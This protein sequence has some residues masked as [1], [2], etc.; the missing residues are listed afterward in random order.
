MGTA[1][2]GKV[3]ISTAL[4]NSE[5]EKST[6]SMVAT[7]AAQYRKAGMSQSDA[8]KKAWSEVEHTSKKGSEKVNRHIHSMGKATQKVTGVFGGLAAVLTKLGGV[9]GTAFAVHKAIE[10]GTESVKAA[11][12]MS[13]ALTGLQSVVEGQGRSFKQA[14]NFIKEYTADGL[15]PATNAINAYKNLSLRGYD[16]SQIRQVIVALKDSSA[17]GR[18]ASLSMGQAVESAS[19]GL[20]NENSILVDNAGV[21]KNVAKMWD[22]YARSIGTTA[23]NLTQQQK[24]Q[25]EVNGILEESKYQAGDAAKVAGTFSGQLMQLSFNFN[26]LKVAVGNA[27]IP[28]AQRILPVINAM[29]AGLTRLANAVA[30]VM[31]AIFGKAQVVQN[32]QAL[33]SSNGQIASSAGVGAAAEKDLAQNTKKAGKAAKGALAAFDELNVLQQN[34]T[35]SA[36]GNGASGG[37]GAAPGALAPAEMEVEDTLSPRLQAIVDKIH[38]LMEPLK[39]INFQPLIDA[40]ERLKEAAAPLTQ[41]LFA[42]LEWAYYHIF[43]PL[44]AWTAEDFLPVFLDVLA[45]ACRVLTAALGALAPLGEWLWN[46]FLAPIAEWTGGVIVT[47][48]NLLADAL[49]RISDWISEH[50]GIVQGMTII[51]AAFMAAWGGTEL[52]IALVDLGGISGVFNKVTN[53]IR[54]CTIAKIKDQIELAG[55]VGLYVKDFVQAMIT[56]VVNIAKTTAAWVANTAAKAASTAA[57]WAQIAATTVWNGI[58]TVATAVTTAFGAAVAF[59]TSPIGLVILAIGAL[60]AVVV[61]LV[62]HWDEVKEVA[63]AVWEKIKETWS[64]V[65]DWFT[66]TV[67]DPLMDAWTAF[68]DSFLK[69]WDGIVDGIKGAINSVIGFVNGMISAVVNGINWVIGALNKLSFDIP[70]WVPG[71]GGE[72]FGFNIPT[73]TPPQIPMLAQGA[74][75]PANRPFLA[76]VGDQ[77]NGTNIEAPLDTIKQALAEVLGQQGAQEIVIKFAASGGLEQL[78]RLLKPYIDRENNRVGAKLITGGVY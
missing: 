78:V 12:A 40:F 8:M 76:M 67:I 9:I 56:S 51:V 62:R 25:A 43:V 72:S 21:T 64:K 26:N 1:S 5:L 45:G 60:I 47:V 77:K 49:E 22:D 18:Q 46:H 74:V 27:I 35:S 17:F 4:D 66:A 10:F 14:Q 6:R 70:D 41:T 50:Q 13:D 7:L 31:G 55:V 44:A 28:V 32:T 48:L 52:A 63:L 34:P 20:K 54:A 75:L 30:T 53:A 58:C 2:D 57:E 33:A 59:L 16:D 42:G 65:C 37:S 23:N 36:P 29:I 61:L 15:V 38:E 69:L 24:I 71:F 19:E 39:Q 73:M 3:T 68:K 11:N